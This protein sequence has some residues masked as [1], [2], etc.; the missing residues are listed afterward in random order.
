[1]RDDQW[2]RNLFT[3]FV[4]QLWLCSSHEYTAL[5][6]FLATVQTSQHEVYHVPIY[7]P[8]VICLS[9]GVLSLT[10]DL[11]VDTVSW[12]LPN[13]FQ[14]CLSFSLCEVE[15]AII[16]FRYSDLYL[17]CSWLGEKPCPGTLLIIT[18]RCYRVVFSVNQGPTHMGSTQHDSFVVDHRM[19]N[20][21]FISGCQSSLRCLLGPLHKCDQSLNT[22]DWWLCSPCC[23]CPQ[24]SWI[25]I[26]AL[27][28]SIYL[29]YMT[30]CIFLNPYIFLS[31]VPLLLRNRQVV[32]LGADLHSLF[33]LE[34][35]S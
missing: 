31:P 19:L 24:I 4:I 17:C 6:L 29:I 30:L 28:Y 34:R 20:L 23:C 22:W 10:I 12:F 18:T 3:Y 21:W 2:N 16:W 7:I 26:H 14:K 25:S 27:I 1:M 32:S 13:S 5:P 11:T 15:N 35:T 33:H 8:W 9:R